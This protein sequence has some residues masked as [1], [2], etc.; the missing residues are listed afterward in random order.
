MATFTNTVRDHNLITSIAG[1]SI[2]DGDTVRLTQGKDA[3]TAGLSN[4]T[5]DLLLFHATPGFMGDIADS[6][7]DFECN[8]TATGKMILEWSGQVIRITSNAGSG[9]I[10]E[11]Q[12]NPAQNGQV[13]ATACL[14]TTA[15]VSAGT[16]LCSDS[17]AVTTLSQTGGV[18]FLDKG[19]TAATTVTLNGGS[20]NL[21]RDVTTANVYAGQL[22][23]DS[24]TCTPTTVNLGGSG[25]V[26]IKQGGNITTLNAQSGTLDLSEL[27]Q[28]ITI[29]TGN[30]GPGLTIIRPR[31]GAA[32][33][34]TTQNNTGSGPRFA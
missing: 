23:I 7:L 29:A 21:N 33:T 18:T 14:I 34:I 28:D 3:Y 26:K 16:L 12:V 11:L 5:I 27:A 31:S 25:V 22:L 13:S 20:C 17:A 19:G 32:Y 8:R 30:V 4:P 10:N 24:T 6:A 2:A 9:T 1:G 15:I